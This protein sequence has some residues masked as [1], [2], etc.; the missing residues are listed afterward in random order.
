VSVVATGQWKSQQ[1]LRGS[2]RLRHERFPSLLPSCPHMRDTGAQGG[3]SALGLPPSLLCPRRTRSR[4]RQ[5]RLGGIQRTRQALALALTRL[6]GGF[7]LRCCLAG[8]SR[9]SLRPAAGQGGGAEQV[10]AVCRW[11]CGRRQAACRASCYMG[12][13]TTRAMPQPASSSP[14][15]RR[16]SA[17]ESVVWQS[18]VLFQSL[19]VTCHLAVDA[20]HSLLGALVRLASLS[21][22][23]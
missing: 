21:K 20:R 8:R 18:S 2:R 6:G 12:Q 4:L 5:L 10:D 9:L 14:S 17:E 15:S 3:G 13:H 22:D 11:H 7:R 16:H 1:S 19:S 23:T